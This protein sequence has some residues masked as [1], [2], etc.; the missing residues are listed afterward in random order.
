[1]EEHGVAVGEVQLLLFALESAGA[2][3]YARNEAL[4]DRGSKQLVLLLGDLDLVVV[5]VLNL[6]LRVLVLIL[7][8]LD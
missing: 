5:R 8:K 7:A 1:M 4:A 6:V 2:L 3:L